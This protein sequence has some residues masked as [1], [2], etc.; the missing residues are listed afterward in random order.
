M[1]SFAAGALAVFLLVGVALWAMLSAELRSRQ[2]Q[3]AQFHADFVTQAIL[4]QGITA[5]DLAGPVDPGREQQLQDLFRTKVLVYPAVGLRVWRPDGTIVLS[6][7]SSALGRG[8]ADPEVASAFGGRTLSRTET[9][10]EADPG[11]T[12]G[13]PPLVYKT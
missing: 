3:A 12:A 13:L 6:N 5:S 10:R 7:D 2:D 9:V 1:T 11:G 4:D 8:Y